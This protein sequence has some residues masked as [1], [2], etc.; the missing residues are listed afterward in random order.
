MP[1]I[2]STSDDQTIRIWNWQSRTQISILTGHCHYVMSADFHPTKDLI[3]SASLD[4][5]LRL[6]DYS[7]LRKKYTSSTGTKRN[8]VVIGNE[9]ELKSIMEGHDR[10]V[11]WCHFHPTLN[12]ICSGADD[13]K[14]KLWKYSG[15]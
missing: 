8:D 13:R 11:N 14:L 2:L 3:V 9:V 10:G 1:W 5:T 12:L 4:Q 7:L 6:W 15:N